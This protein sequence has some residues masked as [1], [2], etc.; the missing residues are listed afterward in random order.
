MRGN[1]KN[2]PGEIGGYWL[3]RRAN[4]DA[5]CRTWYDKSRRQTRR[6][7]LHERDFE[8]AKIALAKWVVENGSPNKDLSSDVPL[9]DVLAFYWLRHAKKLVSAR[10]QRPHIDLLN[11]RIGMLTV[12]E[13]NAEQ[14][15]EFV[16]WMRVERDY[17]DGTIKRVFATVFAAINFAARESR[18][19]VAPRKITLDDSPDREYCATIEELARFYDVPKAEHINRFFLMSL[20]TA[21]R[22]TAV[23]ELTRFQCD[24]EAGL[25]DLNPA[26]RKQTKK[27]RPIVPMCAIARGVIEAT[28]GEY[29]VSFRDKPIRRLQKTWRVAREQADLPSEFIPYALRHTTATELARRGVSI[30]DVSGFLGHRMPEFRSTMRYVKWQPEFQQAAVD[31]L[32]A[33]FDHIAACSNRGMGEYLRSNRVRD[34]AREE[35]LSKGNLASCLGEIGAGDAIRTHDPHLGKV[36]L[37]P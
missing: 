26:G 21:A 24:L 13:F 30:A 35:G 16:D 19:D 23:L 7:S 9:A 11:E 6:A 4:S 27:R 22:P 25:I 29:I 5:W 2:R 32:D 17:S 8:R 33:M 12:A 31:A 34:A 28:D 37:Y 10:V 3:S 14:Q 15:R 36:M 18:I 20:A 1:N